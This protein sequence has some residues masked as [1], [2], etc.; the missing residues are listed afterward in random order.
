[1]TSPA[2]NGPAVSIEGVSKRFR[3]LQDRQSTVKSMV[4]N[5][6]R[7]SRYTELWALENVSFDIAAGTSYGLIGHNGSG[8]STLLKC[9]ARILTPDKGTISVNGRLS[10]LL[11]LGAGFHPELS[12]R[13]NVYLNGSILGM[14]KRDVASRFDDIVEFASL[15][16]FIDAPVR[17]YSSGMYV[18]LG[19]AVAINLEPEI[20]L[21]D[22]I[23]AVGDEA[24]QRRC[25]EQFARLKER[26]CT[27][28]VVSHNLTQVRSFCDEVAWLDTGQLRGTGPA[29]VMID[30]YLDALESPHG[31]EQ[32]RSGPIVSVDLVGPD[33]DPL[34]AV[35]AGAAATF[36]IRWRPDEVDGPVNIALGLYSG[37]LRLAGVN[38]SASGLGPEITSRGQLDYSIDHLSLAPGTYRLAVALHDE[39]MRQVHQRLDPALVFDVAGGT[40]GDTAGHLHLGGR[41]G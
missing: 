7:R 17:N 29:G 12:G 11:E 4:V 6:S 25:M 8:K 24:F 28:V 27:V 16:R 22:E 21:V 10:S 23:M 20:L 32:H 9:M 5:R 1:V 19:F 41:W 3:L 40:G 31:A 35:T 18:R 14:S 2:T 37:A 33:G 36:R 13:E 26:G 30:R 39:T 38:S 15:E 34:E